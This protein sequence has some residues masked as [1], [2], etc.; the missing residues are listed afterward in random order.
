VASA[1][2]DLAKFFAEQDAAER[3]AA[4]RAAQKAVPGQTA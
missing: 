4:E 2:F 1:T 3:E